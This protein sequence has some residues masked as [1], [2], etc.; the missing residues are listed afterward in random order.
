VRAQESQKLLNW[1]FMNFDS[2][3]IYSKGQTVLTSSVWKGSQGDVKLGFNH[4]VYVSLPRG[5]NPKLKPVVERTD[6]LVAPIPQYSRVGTLKMMAD[7]K[8]VSEIPLQAL[9]Q[10]NQATIFGRAFDS[11][12]LMVMKGVSF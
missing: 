9:E 2:F 10:I 7:G 12:R 8:V 4:D 1:G 6:P 5:Y 3:K 11:V